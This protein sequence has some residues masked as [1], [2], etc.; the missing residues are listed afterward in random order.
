MKKRIATLTA[1]LVL[2]LTLAPPDFAQS[3]RQRYL[4]TILPPNLILEIANEASGDEAMHHMIALA[5][6]NRNR[7]A[8]EYVQGYYETAYV[9]NKLKE[10]GI[11]DSEIIG[12]PARAKSTWDAEAA[13]LW[14]LSPEKRKIADLKEVP[15][16]LCSGSG[17]ADVTSELVYVGFGNRE[18][19]YTGK[20]VKGKIVLVNGSPGM[21]K[22][23]A[24]DKFGAAGLIGWGGSHADY[25]V[26][27]IG[28]SS[29]RV[30]ENEKTFGFVVSKRQFDELRDLCER[31]SKV[32]MSA[33][34]RTQM[35][36]YQEEM[37]S[38]LIPGKEF[39]NEE[40]VFTAHLFE[41]FAKQGA[42]DNIS[43][44][45]V[46]LETARAIKK[47]VDD[48]KIPPLKRS[49]RFLFI[50]E[51]S[52]TAA[53]IQKYP[54][55]TKRF[56]A[57]IN[58][59]MVGED[60]VRNRSFFNL[61]RSTWSSPTYLNDVFEALFEWLGKTQKECGE[62]GA[63]EIP[64]VSPNGSL[65]P[66]Y[67]YISEYTGGSDHVVFLDGGVKVPALMLIAWP[68]MWYHT[69]GDTIDKADATQL[70]RV[71]FIT[72]AAAVFLGSA[73]SRE[74]QVMMAETANRG[75]SRVG[76][77][78]L[79]AERMMLNADAATLADAAR[80]AVNVV[81]QGF[82]REKDALASIKFFIRNDAALD[83]LLKARVQAL[84]SLMKIAADD[85]EKVYEQRALREGQ[86]YQKPAPTPDEIRLSRIV[87][88]RTSRMQGYFDSAAFRAALKDIKDLPA[89]KLQGSEYEVRNFIDGRRSILDIRNGV[90]AEYDPIPLKEVENFML[91][92]EKAGFVE[93]QKK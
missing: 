39:P 45:A 10:Y 78:K 42:N 23:L 21:A 63:S 41:G 18:Q 80:E 5:G 79:R 46:I 75:L 33:I 89:Y 87:P 62:Y 34:V 8:E 85:V 1:V 37:V 15:A 52:G 68:D 91:V 22:A 64:V 11:T 47:L 77:D 43:G 12:L 66:F 86:R 26:D 44:C 69:S 51:I 31:G 17:S 27:E 54:E 24:V 48:G 88:V 36:P 81:T 53:Y 9:L 13:E 29:I 90:S 76:K 67:Y 2:A 35:V 57:D 19:S 14:L 6:V 50:P 74:T 83:G 59:D 30:G 40:L 4:E 70:K 16:S 28:W 3:G 84:D 38:A 61:E 60:I 82:V 72:S 49:I 55:I 20:D 65:Q 7:R 58:L 93:L 92:L 73:G 25:D 32:E 71:A 56:F